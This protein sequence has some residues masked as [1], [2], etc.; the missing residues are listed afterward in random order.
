MAA[1]TGKGD[2]TIQERP[3][4]EAVLLSHLYVALLFEVQLLIE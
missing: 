4:F 1:T 2:Y 3:L